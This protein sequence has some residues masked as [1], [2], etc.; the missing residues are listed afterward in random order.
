M[1]SKQIFEGIKVAD[2][3]WMAVGPQATRELAEHGATVVRIESHKRPELMRVNAPYRD[4]IPG[5]DRSA[6]YAAYSTNKYGISLDL[7]RP[8]AR[9]VARKLVAWADIV[10][11][12]YTPGSMAKLGLDYESCRQIKPDIIY[13]STCQ[14]GQKGPYNTLA[15]YGQQGAAYA[16]FSHLTG[17]PDCP[18]V[19]LPNAY[20]DY[21]APWYLCSVL[22]AALNYRRRTGKGLY[23][24][25]AQIEAGVTFWGPGILDYTVNGRTVTRMG[26]RDP[27]MSPHG[28]FP[29]LGQ[30]RWVTIAV[31]TDEEWQALCQAMGNP[32][33]ASESRFATLLG[34]KE[35]EDELE[36]LI[37]EWTKD[38]APH[39]VMAILQAA[40]VPAGAVQ[41]CEDLFNDP[42][43]KHRRHFVPL[44]HRVIG[45]HHYNMPA[46]R[47]SKTPAELRRAAPCLGQDNE[48]VFKEILGYSEDEV[49][50]FLLDGVIT[51]EHDIPDI[52]KPKKPK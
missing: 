44:E 4:G 51:T 5:I 1:A 35:N 19:L 12:G 46:Y 49:A 48:Y 11:D 8:K 50:Q 25:Q 32:E 18:P 29:C 43:V 2:F 10:T 13:L 36:H 30:D 21:I 6:F 47:L 16:G 23:L 28:A 3:A 38:Y 27:N 41:T 22:V 34:R 14:F 20:G 17:W 24:D 42:Q 37:A 9:D 33:W 15:G 39:Q 26:N 31:A 40:G 7:T 45:V 52:L